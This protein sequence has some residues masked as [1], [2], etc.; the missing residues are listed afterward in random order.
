MGQSLKGEL[1]NVEIIPIASNLRDDVRLDEPIKELQRILKGRYTHTHPIINRLVDIRGLVFDVGIVLVLTGGT[2]QLIVALSKLNRPIIYVYIPTMN[3]LPA[4]MEALALIGDKHTINTASINDPVKITSV[5]NAYRALGVLKHMRL[6]LIG[7]A[8]NWLVYSRASASTI[9]RSVGLTLVNISMDEIYRNIDSSDP[10][11]EL[12]SKIMSGAQGSTVSREE[13]E[14]ALGVYQALKGIIKSRHLDAISMR[15]FDLIESKGTTAC[16]AFSLLNSDGIVSGCEG[17]VPSTVGMIIGSLIS[18]K[19]VFMAN[20]SYIK[21]NDL[22]VSH[23]TVPLSMVEGYLLM[24]HFES[25]LGVGIQ[26]TILHSDQVT[27]YRLS[28]DLHRMRVLVGKPII[29]EFD[30]DHCRTQIIIRVN[31]D[32]T[33]IV[34]DSI[35]NHY[36]LILGDHHRELEVIGKLLGGNVDEIV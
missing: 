9:K 13:L 36:L 1:F 23:C 21:G 3:S 26:G 34:E 31:G 12:V 29:P 24:T 2:E 4:L 20:P 19:P 30:D 22:M 7:G 8:S 15:C 18:E 16:V 27:L 10:P 17:D 6:G 33:R 35:G 5:I 32:L 11:A 14:K 28:N 25:G